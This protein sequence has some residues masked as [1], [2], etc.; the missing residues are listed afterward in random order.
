MH[1][2]HTPLKE[3]FQIKIMLHFYLTLIN[4]VE[5]VESSCK[6]YKKFYLFCYLFA[7]LPSLNFSDNN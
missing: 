1:C 7:T 4:N 5:K 3:K 2:K 6:K